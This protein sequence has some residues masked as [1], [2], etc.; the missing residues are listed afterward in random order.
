MKILWSK[1]IIIR[2][3]K[4]SYNVDY[5]LA[6]SFKYSQIISLERTNLSLNEGITVI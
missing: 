6:A 2:I 5:F 4:L 1:S 3:L